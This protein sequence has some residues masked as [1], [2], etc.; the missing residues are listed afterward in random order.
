MKTHLKILLTLIVALFAASACIPRLVPRET[1]E[2]DADSSVPDTPVTEEQDLQAFTEIVFEGAGVIHLVQDVDH[3]IVND[4][5]QSVVNR[6]SYEVRNNVLFVEYESRF[7]DWITVHEYPTITITFEE[8]DRFKFQGGGEISAD[9]IDSDSLVI[10][11]QGGIKFDLTDLSAATF[12]L[13]A[14]GGAAIAVGGRAQ[15]QKVS[16]AGGSS[17]D[18]EDLQSNNVTIKA[19]GGISIVVWAT[20]TLD[21]NLS[22]A[23]NVQYYGN[24]LV[25]QS[26][27]GIGNIEDLGEK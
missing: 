17:Y 15:T 8:L 2:P 23:Y 6:I 26:V 10:D 24:P 22:G 16:L 18:A 12:D 3:S 4:G 19:D 20:E 25:T 13:N 11:I 7:L 21:L 27:Q 1:P 14:E 5:S 9:G